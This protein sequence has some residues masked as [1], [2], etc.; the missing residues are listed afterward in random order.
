MACAYVTCVGEGGAASGGVSECADFWFL[1]SRVSI[2]IWR[3]E[4][5]NEQSSNGTKINE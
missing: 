1:V 5:E 3:G 2:R 4:Q